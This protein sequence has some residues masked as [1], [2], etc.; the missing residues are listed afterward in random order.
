M[1]QN[2]FGKQEA[3]LSIQFKS[4]SSLAHTPKN[5]ETKMNKET[6]LSISDF[7]AEAPTSQTEK[8]GNEKFREIELRLVLP[9]D[10][11]IVA[12][13]TSPSKIQSEKNLT[14]KVVAQ[15]Q[16][17]LNEINEA[18]KSIDE[19]SQ[20][21]GAD[22][23]EN[24]NS[25][26]A[27]ILRRV[28]QNIEDGIF[29]ISLDL[30]EYEVITKANKQEAC[31]DET[32]FPVEHMSCTEEEYIGPY[33]T[34]D[35]T[36]TQAAEDIIEDDEQTIET[37]E[38]NAEDSAL[39]DDISSAED[40]KASQ[41]KDSKAELIEGGS[42][43]LQQK[44]DLELFKVTEHVDEQMQQEIQEAKLIERHQENASSTEHSIQEHSS[45]TTKNVQEDEQ[46]E[47]SDPSNVEAKEVEQ[48]TQKFQETEELADAT[49]ETGV[50][51]ESPE[52]PEEESKE[53]P[54]LLVQVSDENN[55]FFMNYDKN[56]ADSSEA[57]TSDDL[58]HHS[59]IVKEDVKAPVELM[60][61][62]EVVSQVE[63]VSRYEYS[64]YEPNGMLREERVCQT[65]P[66]I[67]EEAKKCQREKP[68][69]NKAICQADETSLVVQTGCKLDEDQM[70]AVF[71][72]TRQ[73]KTLE[74]Q[75][76]P[77]EG[78][79]P[80]T[81]LNNIS[82]LALKDGD[83]GRS[84][85]HSNESTQTLVEKLKE[86]KA[87]QL[88]K[89]AASPLAGFYMYDTPLRNDPILWGHISSAIVANLKK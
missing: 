6:P 64:P 33:S 53:L 19:A 76:A 34:N 85:S 55:D 81:K 31:Q 54:E 36:N 78:S 13:E 3:K 39:I 51:A 79:A 80:E 89:R 70:L 2:N 27:N 14:L 7:L 28:D 82:E 10:S 21:I 1:F 61:S 25:H 15:S 77:L 67:D 63:A 20:E 62:E 44:E 16:F 74:E 41:K 46:W 5:L 23:N 57:E 17:E 59:V 24:I 12:N 58:N 18:D 11:E 9:D 56:L 52:E 38:V 66:E 42:E 88:F 40:T 87:E 71:T 65:E 75:V 72:K 43:N 35:F 30:F 45:A 26:E 29:Q 84:R 49:E 47:K 4:Q 68:L 69:T 50:T 86:T 83:S 22:E 48:C 73:Q 32:S 60:V 37:I 8:L